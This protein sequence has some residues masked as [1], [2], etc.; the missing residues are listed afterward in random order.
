MIGKMKNVPK[1]FLFFDGYK[2]RENSTSL[3]FIFD[4][5]IIVYECVTRYSCCHDF[6]VIW[7][8][9]GV[10]K[11]KVKRKKTN[12]IKTCKTTIIINLVC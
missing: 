8:L 2:K 12:N 6:D 11:R 9:W 3:S 1:Y 5:H 7:V 10:G 4:C